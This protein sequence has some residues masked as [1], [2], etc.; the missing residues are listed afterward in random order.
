[1]NVQLRER[2][3]MMLR[4]NEAVSERVLELLKEQNMTQ[5][6]LFKRT[7]LPKSTISSIINCLH[8]S[9]KLRI[10]HEMCQGFGIGIAEFFDSP[11]FDEDNLE[12]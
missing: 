11:L 9:V 7:G 1:M 10:I 4:L 12:P 8:P 2:V 5:Y 3:V 6:Q